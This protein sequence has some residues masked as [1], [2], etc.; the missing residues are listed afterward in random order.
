MTSDLD[1]YRSANVLLQQYGAH[2]AL[3]IAAKRADALFDLGELDGQRV[4]KD[5]LAAIEE[6][7]RSTLLPG[8]RAN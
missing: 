1:V 8:E 7:T 3:L 6:L 4:W 5:V 2:E